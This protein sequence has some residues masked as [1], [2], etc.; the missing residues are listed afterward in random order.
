MDSENI[1]NAKNLKTAALIATIGL[2]IALTISLIQTPKYKAS[3]KLLVIFNQENMDI[4][5]ASQTSNYLS[6]VL[7]EVVY[8]NSFI[9]NV[10]ESKFNLNDNLSQERTERLKSWRKMVRVKSRQNK[11]IIIIDVFHHDRNQAGEF[12]Q[13]ISYVLVTKH[14]LYHGSG[15]KVALKII[16]SPSA[17]QHWAHPRT[18]QNGLIGLFAG[19]IVGLTFIVIFPDQQLLKWLKT[20]KTGRRDE[21]IELTKEEAE[22]LSAP[23]TKTSETSNSQDNFRGFKRF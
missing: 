11:G 9:K 5:T 3:A 4:Y 15:D 7:S 13:A 17:S 16:D 8:S 19:I 12:A 6:E 10:F 23:E 1:F 21:T 2:I 20:K 18:L 14:K 22:P